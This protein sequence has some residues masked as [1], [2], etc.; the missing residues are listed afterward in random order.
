MKVK[1][2]NV[3]LYLNIHVNENADFVLFP[4][5]PYI[6]QITKPILLSNK[7]NVGY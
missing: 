7:D 1:N 2:K 4:R 6:L 3:A 5:P